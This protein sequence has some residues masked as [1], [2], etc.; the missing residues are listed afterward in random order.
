[1][2]LGECKKYDTRPPTLTLTK[3]SSSPRVR[4]VR[5]VRI[6]H[7]GVGQINIMEVEVYSGGTNVA[8]QGTAELSST[9]TH[10]SY[11]LVASN[12]IDGDASNSMALAHSQVEY[13]TQDDARRC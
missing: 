2:A 8:L 9:H 3:N 1:M 6:Q 12:A 13:G 11:N 7:N 5:S 10:S 4:N